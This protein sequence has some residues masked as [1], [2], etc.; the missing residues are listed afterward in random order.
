[1]PSILQ[2]ASE[3]F[4]IILDIFSLIKH[5]SFITFIG[6]I[7]WN[8]NIVKVGQFFKMMDLK[9]LQRSYGLP[10]FNEIVNY[11]DINELHKKVSGKKK[12]MT[13]LK[14]LSA[15]YLGITFLYFIN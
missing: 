15:F 13:S 4:Y 9:Y 1:M 6:E 2:L 5:Q 10:C 8:P 12:P 3:N 14:M 11:E 7:F